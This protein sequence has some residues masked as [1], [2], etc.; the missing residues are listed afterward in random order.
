[1]PYPAKLSVAVSYLVGAVTQVRPGASISRVVGVGGGCRR[2][3]SGY[4]CCGL[5]SPWPGGAVRPHGRCQPE[6][7]EVADDSDPT[8]GVPARGRMA[9]HRCVAAGRVLGRWLGQQMADVRGRPVRHHPWRWIPADNSRGPTPRTTPPGFGLW[10]QGDP[11]LVRYVP[12]VGNHRWSGSLPLT[13]SAE[14][15]PVPQALWST[16][17]VNVGRP[18]GTL[19]ST[20]T[21]SPGSRPSAWLCLCAVRVYRCAGWKLHLKLVDAVRC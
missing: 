15:G 9:D 3:Q 11:S 13:W 2:S 18:N 1:M 12:V 19:P 8:A 4:H 14:V 5:V 21:E 7:S 20:Q 10:P 17:V 16:L 6:T